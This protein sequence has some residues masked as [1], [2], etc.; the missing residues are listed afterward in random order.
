LSNDKMLCV[1]DNDYV[2]IM[3]YTLDPLLPW[4]VNMVQLQN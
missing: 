2:Y 3:M 1:N 4:A